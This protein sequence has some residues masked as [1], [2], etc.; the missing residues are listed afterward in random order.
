LHYVFD[1]W[2]GDELIES[3][4]CF[5][6][7]E[8]LATRLSNSGFSGFKLADVEITRSEQ[9]HDIYGDRPL[10]TF[11]W[12]QVEGVPGQDDFGLSGRAELVVSEAARNVLESFPLSHC[13]VREQ[14][15]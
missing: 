13:E 7:S 2:L 15:V 3:F 1:G 12:L 6:V 10:P 11:R 14:M 4:P 8:R 5:I 9:Y